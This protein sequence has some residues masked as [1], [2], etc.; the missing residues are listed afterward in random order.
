MV[1]GATQLIAVGK[2]D[3]YLTVNP[4]V[5]IFQYRY[6]RYINYA[7]ELLNIPLNNS[8]TFGGQTYVK[9]PKTGGH[10]LSK[11][12][13]HIKLPALVS[14][15][16]LRYVSWS[17][18]LGYSLFSRP[19]EL[20][21]GGIIVD[22]LYPVCMDMID[23][24]SKKVKQEGYNQMIL[25]GDMYRDSIYNASQEVDLMIP[26]SFWFTRDYIMSLPLLCMN[27][28][29]QDI[30]INFYFNEFKDVINYNTST[31]PDSKEIISSDVYV[32]YIILDQ[33]IVEKYQKEKQQYVI[34]QM[35]YNGDEIITSGKNLYSTTLDFFHPS[36]EIIF[37]CVD[38]NNIEN[39][40]YFNYGRRSDNLP[41]ISDIK[42]L[43]DG[44]NRY[45][46][47]YLPEFIFRQFFPYNV[48]SVVPTKYM[49]IMP[50][51]INPD[52]TMNKGQ[53][54]GSVN[55]GRYDEVTL[56]LQMNSNN[57]SCR[58]YIYSIALNIITFENGVLTFEWMNNT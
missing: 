14:S 12:Y 27:H 19:I 10:L 3:V 8:A 54:T 41:L 11:I 15:E 20:Q 13:L 42:L 25:R 22:K 9:I 34:T 2:E 45:D 44:N 47:T 35:V 52:D 33:I 1:C 48:H 56:S 26:L 43:L 5:N 55:L 40:C 58:L 38:E 39:N 6:Y 21:I 51:A 16:P 57:P 46:I 28:N 53:P 36:Q 49:Y 32:E 18:T 50:F 4:Q 30:Q 37:A 31:E 29:S 7:N 24:L 23:E 17:D